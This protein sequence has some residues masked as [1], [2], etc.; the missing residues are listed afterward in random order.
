MNFLIKDSF[1]N[2]IATET[3]ESVYDT[4][5]NLISFGINTDYDG[6]YTNLYDAMS[7]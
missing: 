1:G 6:R 5:G 3:I 2:I 7:T 4:S